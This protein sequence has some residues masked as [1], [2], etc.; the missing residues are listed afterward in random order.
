[1][2]AGAARGPFTAGSGSL[3]RVLTLVRVVGGTLNTNEIK[4]F[5]LWCTVLNYMV[6]FIWFGAFVFA[7]DWIRRM[8]GRWFKLSDEAFDAIHYGGLAIFKI[9]IILFNLVP[10]L[11]ISLG[12]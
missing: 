8:H 4:S 12:R 3:S 11:A 2:P 7:N 6:L 1:V 5:L 9:G 10:L